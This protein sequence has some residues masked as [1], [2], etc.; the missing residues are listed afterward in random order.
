MRRDY[1]QRPGG[2]RISTS[3]NGAE[4]EKHRQPCRQVLKLC[5][6]RPEFMLDELYRMKLRADRR[7]Y[8]EEQLR[9]VF[10]G[11]LS[12]L[13][14]FRRKISAWMNCASGTPM[15][16]GSPRLAE[17]FYCSRAICPNEPLM[18]R[19]NIYGGVMATRNIPSVRTLP[20]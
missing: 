14:H 12:K 8:S 2:W 17:D 20:A 13:G 3:Q 19:S 7:Q 4:A 15:S 18:K 6:G 10:I 11:K 9:S 1:Q 16:D 5:G